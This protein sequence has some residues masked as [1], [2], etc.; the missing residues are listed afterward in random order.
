[1][2]AS[3]Q[4]FKLGSWI[5]DPG[6]RTLVNEG[7]VSK[8]KPRPMK[9][10]VALVKA[11]GEVVTQEAFFDTI[12]KGKTP[13]RDVLTVAIS[14]LRATLADDARHPNIIETVPRGYRLL[15]PATPVMPPTV[16]KK[17]RNAAVT[18]LIMALFLLAA[19]SFL[20]PF[21]TNSYAAGQS[22]I[23]AMRPFLNVT[24]QGSRDGLALGIEDAVTARLSRSQEVTVVRL[25]PD[26]EAALPGGGV[27]VILEGFLTQTGADAE[28]TA[29]LLEARTGALLWSRV[30]RLEPDRFHEV[31]AGIAAAVRL[32]LE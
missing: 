30:Y 20:A 26:R 8:L 9:V 3:S 32:K 10:L 13:S 24:G 22:K 31:L 25:S 23:L 21:G 27:D 16:V 1:M 18:A 6:C 17:K 2:V 19:S 4:R 5:V 7:T 12:W 28:V 14:H 15:I 11:K 29:R